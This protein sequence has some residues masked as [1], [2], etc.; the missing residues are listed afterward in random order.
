M[1]KDV[2]LGTSKLLQKITF[3]KTLVVMETNL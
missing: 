1:M 3:L 2:S